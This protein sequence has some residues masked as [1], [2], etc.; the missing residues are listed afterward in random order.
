[1]PTPL[2]F[3]TVHMPPTTMWVEARTW[4]DYQE[5]GFELVEFEPGPEWLRGCFS[6]RAKIQ[7]K[8]EGEDH[9]YSPELCA[10]HNFVC[11]GAIG[12]LMPS[13]E[14]R[15]AYKSFNAAHSVLFGAADNGG[16]EYHRELCNG[17]P[18]DTIEA[19]RDRV[20]E[21][22]RKLAGMPVA[23]GS[24]KDWHKIADAIAAWEYKPL[25]AEAFE[26]KP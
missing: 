12:T 17:K 18:G 21:G 3:H 24:A 14:R 5:Q 22:V 4:R 7:M 2:T 20:A 6:G 8:G 19:V 23:K 9:T 13:Y 16:L 10:L 15:V 26:L 25:P 11:N 1:M